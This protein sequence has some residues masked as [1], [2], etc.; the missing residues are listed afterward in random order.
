VR[1]RLF[2]FAAALCAILFAFVVVAWLAAH[3]MDPYGHY[4]SL[5]SKY[6]VSLGG[7]GGGASL[8]VFND[9]SY[10]PYSGSIIAISAVGKSNPN[11]PRESSFDA[12]GVY[13]RS[14]QW[15]DGK[16]LWTFSLSLLYPL[17]MCGIL[18]MVWWFRRPR[19]QHRGFPI[20]RV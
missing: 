17:I 16:S 20:D 8:H 1:N 5:S 13:Y 12:P 11:D 3:A 4:L 7:R 9:S 10:G 6:H 18:P 2:N 19:Q 14:L 15:R